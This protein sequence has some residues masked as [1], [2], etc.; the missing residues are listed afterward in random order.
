[1]QVVSLLKSGGKAICI[2][3]GGQLFNVA[4]KPIREVFIEKGYIEA[5]IGLPK[6]VL[7]GT[8]IA[9]KLIVFSFGN[10]KIHMVD[11][12]QYF[13][14]GRRTNYL[15]DSDIDNIYKAYKKN[16]KGVSYDASLKDVPN[17]N[18]SLDPV[19][20]TQDKIEIKNGIPLGDLLSGV[21]RGSSLS[22]MQ[23]EQIHSN[24]PTK[25][26]YLM[27]KDIT[28]GQVSEDLPY[29]KKIPE[30]SK[31]Y[32]VENG[33]IVLSKI[34]PNFK[35][36]IIEKGENEEILTTGN[37]YILRLNESKIPRDFIKLFLDSKQGQL[38]LQTFSTGST[39][40]SISVDALKKI[41]IPKLS[42][43]QIKKAAEKYSNLKKEISLH[44]KAIKKA[45]EQIKDLF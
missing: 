13:Q 35:V 16:I 6:N 23:L 33:D 43:A 22:R 15:N 31:K 27:L 37:L 34:G 17:F 4:T 45:E 24:N 5:I 42:D 10:K 11:G 7:M 1:M 40:Q 20:Y 19:H 25:Y 12:S 26:R 14:K 28:N 21:S 39:M 32:C 38:Q 9:P 2:T 30:N 44:K 8:S 18:F 36:A 3:T 41:Q 29:I